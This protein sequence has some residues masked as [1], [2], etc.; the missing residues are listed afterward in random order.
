MEFIRLWPE[1]VWVIVPVRGGT[2]G[3]PRG[4]WLEDADG[5]AAIE[6]EVSVG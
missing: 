6:L 2:A 5:E 1:T 4:W 3:A